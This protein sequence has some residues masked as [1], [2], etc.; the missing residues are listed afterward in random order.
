MSPKSQRGSRRQVKQDD[1]LVERLTR[2]MQEGAD[3]CT[4]IHDRCAENQDYVAGGTQWRRGDI[5]AQ[6][7]KGRPHLVLNKLLHVV[8]AIANREMTQRF[9]ATVFG[10]SRT[11]HELAEPLD[12]FLRWQR[13]RS[14]A[15]HEDSAAFRA[16]VIGGYACVHTYWDPL[17]DEGNGMIL[18]EEIPIWY[19]VWDPR[20][21]KQNLTD[22]RWHMCGKYVSRIEAEEEYGDVSKNAKRLFS[23]LTNYEPGT[24]V[25]KTSGTGR[26]PWQGPA[27]NRWYNATDDEI[28]LVEAEWRDVTTEYRAAIPVRF[29]E[30]A[31]LASDPMAQVQLA[32]LQPAEGEEP[33]TD[34][35][36]GEP[37]PPEPRIVTGQ[38]FMMMDDQARMEIEDEMLVET[39][40]TTYKTRKELDEFSERYFDVLGRD[41][42]DFY[43]QKRYIYKYAV[44]TDGTILETGDRGAGF[45]Y[46]FLTGFPHPN[47]DGTTFFGFVDV[48]KGPQDWRNTFMNL[49]LTRLAY[50]PKQTILVEETAVE[51][52][53]QFY[54]DL[55]NPRGAA[56]VPDGFVTSNRYMMLP[57]VAPPQLEPQLIAMADSG[58]TELAGLSGIELGQQS[59]L[60]RVSGTVV[61]SVRES[62]NTI[63]A[64]LFDSL[65]R[66]RM[67]NA[68]LTLDMMQ[69]LYTPEQVVRIVGDEKGQ[70]LAP[71]EEW[72]DVK[73][74]DLKLDEAEVSSTEKQDFFDKMTRTGT[75]EKWVEQDRI[76]FEMVI[77]SHPAFSGADKLK[78]RE[79]EKKKEQL[80]QLQQQVEDLTKQLQQA[81][82]GAP[83]T[84]PEGGGGGG[85]EA[86]PP[87]Q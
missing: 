65:R 38:E 71:W 37:L 30:L 31:W 87:A 15:E 6:D 39:K 14:E 27:T 2:W 82:Q 19:T 79:H 62:S 67:R 77:D 56:I 18:N 49:M 69:R 20:A 61:Q 46:E 17:E 26:G 16:A 57:A 42:E 84:P 3:F 10:R 7:A 36:T 48:A 25:V 83:P 72:P 32:P 21:R 51:D 34:P 29:D 22:R 60:R 59:D 13:D 53:Q 44:M 54:N 24:D 68:R 28:F 11:D 35:E 41:F 66:F 64:I 75:L 63:L 1:L 43:K 70:Y 78:V 8:N 50:S 74:F 9:R 76:P 47:Y 81:Q 86:A 12:E 73:R 80:Q 33:E 45:T 55:A 4:P 58:I 5:E 85:E 23:K 40:L 52:P